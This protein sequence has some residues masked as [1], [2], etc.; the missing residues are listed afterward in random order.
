M[1]W[2]LLGDA[3]PPCFSSRRPRFNEMNLRLERRVLRTCHM[4]NS[5]S[6]F[7]RSFW[8]FVTAA[9]EADKRAATLMVL[10]TIVDACSNAALALGL[11][12]LV[13]AIIHSRWSESMVAVTL[14]V[15]SLLV[16]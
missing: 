12:V 3:M 8:L 13:D 9:Y 15:A 2:S 5:I 16:S 14:I 6:K 11:K 7:W 1:S 4:S 10:L